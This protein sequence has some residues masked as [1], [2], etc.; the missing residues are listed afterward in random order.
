MP[1]STQIER[2]YDGCGKC[3]V[4]LRRLSRSSDITSSPGKQRGQVLA[5]VQAYGGH[6]IAWA[7]DWEVSGATDPM[8]RPN[9]GPWLRGERGPYDGVAGAAVDR[10]GRNVRDCLNTGFMMSEQGLTLLT[11][12]HD[13]PWDLNDPNDENRFM[14]EAWGAQME[15]RS[16]QRR[17]RE[18][19]EKNRRDGKAGGKHQYG[20]RYERAVPTGPVTAQVFDDG[21]TL[22]DEYGDRENAHQI[23]M[24][25]KARIMND[26]TGKITPYSEAARLNREG[27]HLAPSDHLRVLYGR[28]PQGVRWSGKGIRS[29]LLNKAYLGYQMFKGEPVLD[30]KG[31]PRRIAPEMWGYADHVALEAK[32][33]TKPRENWNPKGAQLLTDRIL[34]GHCHYRG[35]RIAQASYGCRTDHEGQAAPTIRVAILDEI[36]E[37]WFLV[38]YGQGDVWET[39]FEPG[40]GVAARIAEVEASRARLRSDREA[41]LYDSLDDAEWFKS[42]YRDMGKE[43]MKL[44]AEPDRPGGMVHRP[45]G[46]TVEDVWNRLDVVGRNEMLAAFDIK[47]TL[48]NTK[49]PRRWFAGRVHGP[50]RD[51]NSVPN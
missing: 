8:Q 18:T 48:W 25:I 14:M 34:C 35:Y 20:Y 29:M 33:G 32:L 24:Y 12:G 45:T 38:T 17:N 50:E 51:P 15:L 10:L 16:I 44:R 28:Q 49:A 46:E 21:S 4:G 6:I 9:L 2:P 23:L 47:V 43:L 37:D 13:G 11:Y 7:D 39:V 1:V 36:A 30:E 42:R 19:A 3:L 26:G 22:A 40:N 31:H 5:A 41:G 27:V